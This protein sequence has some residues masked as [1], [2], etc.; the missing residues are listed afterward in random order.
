MA[1]AR[2]QAGGHLEQL[3]DGDP[4]GGLEGS[5]Q[6]PAPGEGA[7]LVEQ[8]RLQ[9]GGH[10]NRIATPEQQA[11]ASRQS[12]A[13]RDHRGGGQAQGAGTGHHQHGDGELQRQAE[14]G[15]GRDPEHAVAGMANVVVIEMEHVGPEG[16]AQQPPE[17]EGGHGQAQHH[18]GEPT[19]HPIGEALD[20]RL[21]RLGLLH[22]VNDPGHGALGSTALH[23]QHQGSFQ[24]EAAS[25]QLAAC[26]CLQRQ[27]LTG[28]GRHIH[29]RGP[30][31]HQGI[32]RHAVTWQ[33]LHPVAGA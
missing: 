19:G 9:P 4:I 22:H 32:H 13:H 8:H 21:A 7:G 2:F 12:G 24:V 18:Q 23:L 28:E 17:Q 25:G 6:G 27:G 3:I 10:L 30:L 26:R 1:R 16:G 33:Q 15:L 5:D 20:R 11:R 29:R 14:G 31:Q